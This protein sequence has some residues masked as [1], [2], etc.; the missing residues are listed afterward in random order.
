MITVCGASPGKTRMRGETFM[1]ALMG[2]DTLIVAHGVCAFEKVRFSASFHR[3]K[4][5]I[6]SESCSGQRGRL[7]GSIPASHSLQHR[8]M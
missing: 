1:P 5:T 4:V 2:V 7:V 6:V 3:G 8:T